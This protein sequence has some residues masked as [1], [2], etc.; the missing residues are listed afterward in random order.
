MKSI[1]IFFALVHNGI[2]IEKD[3]PDKLFRIESNFTTCG[4]YAARTAQWFR[5]T[6][7][8]RLLIGLMWFL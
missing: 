5:R 7:T 1:E 2:G 8:K 3:E 6:V 4:K